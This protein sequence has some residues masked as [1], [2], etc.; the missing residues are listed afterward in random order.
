MSQ[1]VKRF[2]FFQQECLCVNLF[3]NLPVSLTIRYAPSE[4]RRMVHQVALAGCVSAFIQ[5][6]LFTLSL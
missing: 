5:N 2:F 4:I 1:N 6:E 3:A